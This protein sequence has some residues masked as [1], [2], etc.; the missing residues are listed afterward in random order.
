MHGYLYQLVIYF[1]IGFGLPAGPC[2]ISI[3]VWGSGCDILI[4]E[5]WQ[6]TRKVGNV[7]WI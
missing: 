6:N 4:E 5:H 1:L 2:V 3:G 7:W